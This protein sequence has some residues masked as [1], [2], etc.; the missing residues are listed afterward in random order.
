M[1]GVMTEEES[2]CY[3]FGEEDTGI[4]NQVCNLRVWIEEFTK[5]SSIHQHMHFKGI[6]FHLH[7]NKQ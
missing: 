5:R 1:K 3:C 7:N 4:Y 2:R 6:F